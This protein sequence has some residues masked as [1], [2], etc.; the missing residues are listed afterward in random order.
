MKTQDCI[1]AKPSVQAPWICQR[2]IMPDQGPRSI[3]QFVPFCAA[4]FECEWKGRLDLPEAQLVETVRA[5]DREVE[6]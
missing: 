2:W 4:D 6:D 5:K 1:F 3:T